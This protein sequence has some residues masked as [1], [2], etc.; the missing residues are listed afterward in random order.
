MKPKAIEQL[1][2]VVAMTPDPRWVPEH[3]SIK[4][5]AEKLLAKLQ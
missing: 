5:K 1:K 3:P 4:A 2:G